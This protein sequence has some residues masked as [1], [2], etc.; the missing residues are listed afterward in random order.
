MDRG[1]VS[2]EMTDYMSH[3]MKF[4]QP[5]RRNPKMIDYSI[6]MKGLFTYRGRRI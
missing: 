5:L 3:N 2:L 4:I 1:F 6:S